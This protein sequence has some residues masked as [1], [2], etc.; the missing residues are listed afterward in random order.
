MRKSHQILKDMEDSPVYK[1]YRKATQDIK[2]Y[3]EANHEYEILPD[4][5]SIDLLISSEFGN[6]SGRENDNI[7]GEMDDV[8]MSWVESMYY[9]YQKT[10]HQEEIE[11]GIRSES[12]E[13]IIGAYLTEKRKAG[14]E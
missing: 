5:V 7:K 12:G 1:I 11:E 2:T 10:R 14:G 8:I 4:G 3:L 9:K 6:S 13:L